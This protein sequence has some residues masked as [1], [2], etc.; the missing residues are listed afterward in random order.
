MKFKKSMALLLSLAM[1]ITPVGVNAQ[2]AGVTENAATEESETKTTEDV[3]IEEVPDEEE[4]PAEGEIPSDEGEAPVEEEAPAEEEIPSDE[5]ETPAE[6]ETPSDTEAPVE[7]ETPVEE[8]VLETELID[9]QITED[10][11]VENEEIV[12]SA[13][14]EDDDT[15]AS[16]MMN[17]AILLDFEN[18]REIYA[19]IGSGETVVRDSNLPRLTAPGYV[20]WTDTNQALMEYGSVEN[21]VKYEVVLLKLK[22]GGDLYEIK[23]YE[24]IVGVTIPR[25]LA[26]NQ[27]TFLPWVN[28]S[29]SYRVAVRGIG[30]GRNYADSMYRI[31]AVFHYNRP[32]SQL[33]TPAGLTWKGKNAAW[34]PVDG[35]ADYSVV[36][37]EDGERVARA[38]VTDTS[39]DWSKDM[40]DSYTYVFTVTALSSNINQTAHSEAAGPSE[41]WVKPDENKTREF[42][43]RMYR[44]ALNRNA[45]EEGLNDWT[46]KL[47]D[48]EVDGSSF[49]QGIIMSEE[50]TNRKLNDSDFLNVLY[51]AFFD[52]TADA[53]GKSDWQK[54][55]VNGISREYVLAGFVN[56]EEF[57]NLCKSYGIMRGEYKL[58]NWRDKNEGVTM[59]VNRIYTKALGREGEPDGLE[60]WTGRIL[61]KEM[62][63]EDVAK[64]F[65][66]SDEFSNKGLNNTEFVKVL[67]RT[68]MGREYDQS[69]LEDWVGKLNAGTSREEVLEGFSRSTEFANIMKEYGL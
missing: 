54:K 26:T 4:T 63:P 8:E 61:R 21:A 7:E 10:E 49:S 25:S 39:C 6:G 33:A 11:V 66:F 59:F 27:Y 41:A 9:F 20:R 38:T 48:G 28:E 2:E 32:A 52:R 30:D 53:G 3:L 44:V 36:L 56:S 46:Q 14:E 43:A 65:F 62:S 58:G 42:V 16:I 15:L 1:L 31:S 50:F 45:E 40:E 47:V 51:K 35:A 55:L 69:G 12:I 29:G 24:G 68:F 57:A 17:G 5:G 19:G 13:A 34:Q 23:D 37:Y 67:Y 60:D 22:D 18:D 64:S